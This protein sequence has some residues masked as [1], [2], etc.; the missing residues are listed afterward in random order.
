MPGAQYRPYIDSAVW[1]VEH[2]KMEDALLVPANATSLSIGFEVAERD[3]H[4]N[5]MVGGGGA[6]VELYL[7]DSGYTLQKTFIYESDASGSSIPELAWKKDL[8]FLNATVES[9]VARYQWSRGESGVVVGQCAG[10]TTD[11]CLGIYDTKG[12]I[13]VVKTNAT[14]DPDSCV[15]IF[16]TRLVMLTPSQALEFTI[17]LN[18][19]DLGES[20]NDSM[21]AISILELPR[22]SS[23]SIFGWTWKPSTYTQTWDNKVDEYWPKSENKGLST[24]ALVGIIVASVVVVAGA[25]GGLIWRRRQRR[26][27]S[28]TTA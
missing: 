20:G 17:P 26:G 16:D 12:D 13:H 8:T 7:V 11:T 22:D 15:A 23:Y 18:R 19:T 2:V 28:S 9:K 25:V 21:P 3:P 4:I 14:Y 1:A 5:Q 24:G 6:V 27:Q 10:P